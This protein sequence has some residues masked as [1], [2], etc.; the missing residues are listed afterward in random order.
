MKWLT[1][2]AIDIVK[3]SRQPVPEEI[4]YIDTWVKTKKTKSST[5]IKTTTETIKRTT[6]TFYGKIW[7]R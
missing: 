4:N 2:R 5:S 1:T 6:N 3:F 7:R